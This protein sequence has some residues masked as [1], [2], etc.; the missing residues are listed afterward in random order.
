MRYSYVPQRLS[1]LAHA[2]VCYVNLHHSEDIM[3]RDSFI[4]TLQG[5][6]GS[7][8]GRQY[9]QIE[10]TKMSDRGLIECAELVRDLLA[11]SRSSDGSVV[12][13]TYRSEATLPTSR[14]TL[15]G[16]RQDAEGARAARR[17][18]SL[19]E[20]RFARAPLKVPLF[21]CV[22]GGRL[23]EK[24]VGIECFMARQDLPRD[25]IDRTAFRARTTQSFCLFALAAVG[26]TRRV[27]IE[28]R[29]ISGGGL[30]FETGP[31]RRDVQDRRRMLGES[32]FLSH[33]RRAG[34][35]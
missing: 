5:C 6:I 33:H 1:V 34:R 10:W 18:H 28:C 14:K 23:Y 8:T 19:I 12:F 27:G 11:N 3:D 31:P 2:C 7:A 15:H 30:S 13:S 32:S 22:G 4:R 17:E 20:R 35:L 24:A 21:I 16:A 9:S 26:S 29:D 25:G